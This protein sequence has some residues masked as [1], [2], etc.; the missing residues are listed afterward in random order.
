MIF[1][2]SLLGAAAIGLVA[3]SV[4]TGLSALRLPLLISMPAHLLVVMI[5]GSLTFPAAAET[6]LSVREISKR[7][8]AE[9]GVRFFSGCA[10]FLV[11]SLSVLV[12]HGAGN[13][14]ASRDTVWLLAICVLALVGVI[15]SSRK[16]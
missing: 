14:L 3:G 8:M 4:F 11:G 7:E 16:Q 9:L 1:T 5:A 6:L 15:A 12:W 10:G 13:T 2:R